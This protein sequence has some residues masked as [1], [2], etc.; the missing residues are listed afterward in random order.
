MRLSDLLFAIKYNLPVVKRISPYGLGI[1]MPKPKL[2][3]K[4]A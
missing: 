1:G 2:K 4:K 3:T